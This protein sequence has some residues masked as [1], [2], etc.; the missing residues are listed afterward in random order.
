MPE[1]VRL[2]PHMEQVLTDPTLCRAL[3]RANLGAWVMLCQFTQPDP[4]GAWW[5]YCTVQRLAALWGV[6][7]PTADNIITALQTEGLIHRVYGDPHGPNRGKDASY[8]FLTHAAELPR[9][10]TDPTPPDR[11]TE[12]FLP[13]KD[14][15]MNRAHL[16]VVPNAHA[17]HENTAPTPHTA[18]QR[19]NSYPSH[20]SGVV[21][22]LTQ[23]TP[24]TERKLRAVSPAVRNRYKR[25]GW[26]GNHHG[27]EQYDDHLLL[28]A[29]DWFDNPL[30]TEGMKTPLAI[31]RTT[32]ERGE[33]TAF[34]EHRHIG[35]LA[36]PATP[37]ES[38]TYE[39]FVALSIEDD[40]WENA[41]K[42]EAA[43][44]A[45]QSGLS[46]TT[47]EL[48]RRVGWEWRDKHAT[49][50]QQTAD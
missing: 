22:S 1:A 30:N 19:Q 33:L 41:V 4:T 35:G 18:E 28:A 34:C 10:A 3:G 42:A 13:V 2:P 23:H 27:F 12:R 24:P 7:R 43:R 6:S 50:R 32:I 31:L 9:P 48:W 37:V 15:P 36:K 11:T 39:E 40:D 49:H 44:R 26:V 8:W 46:M 47:S 29:A 16:A 17:P 25:L 38:L 20:V 21:E 14:L 45:Q 5:A